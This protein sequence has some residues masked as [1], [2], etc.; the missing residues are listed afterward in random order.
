[1]IGTCDGRAAKLPDLAR[2]A[3][4]VHDRH[5]NIEKDQV[6]GMFAR[7]Q[8]RVFAMLDGIDFAPHFGQE[9]GGQ[10]A[11]G[12]G[13]FGEQICAAANHP[14]RRSGGPAFAMAQS[15]FLAADQLI[16]SLPHGRGSTPACWL[17]S[18]RGS[19][20]RRLATRG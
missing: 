16:C 4:A 19:V 20:N 2:R 18:L 7:M 13:V 15:R 17:Q 8:E 12:V 11:C 6:I 1:M 14:G 10:G 9:C 3:D 5:F